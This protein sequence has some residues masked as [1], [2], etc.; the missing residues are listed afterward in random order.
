[1][2][3]QGV[4]DGGREA[5]LA[6]AQLAEQVLARMSHRLEVG[7]AE[8]RAAP[9]DRVERAE[10]ASQGLP[11]RGRLLQT[12]QINVELVQV[13]VTLDQEFLGG[14]LEFRHTLT[15]ISPESRGPLRA[16]RS[17]HKWPPHRGSG[18]LRVCPGPSPW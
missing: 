12:H 13:L 15:S 16:G 6:V 17:C 8:E 5:Q 7:E 1:H 11:G 9:L 4:G 2:P 10:D 18:W 14:F 3:Q